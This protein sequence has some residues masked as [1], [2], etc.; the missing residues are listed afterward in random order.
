[1]AKTALNIGVR[2]PHLRPRR[3]PAW[4]P[5]TWRSKA[6][7][8]RH[9]WRSRDLRRRRAARRRPAHTPRHWRVQQHPLVRGRDALVTTT[10]SG[11]ARVPALMV[12]RLRPPAP[13]P[14][15][16]R[17]GLAIHSGSALN[18]AAQTAYEASEVRRRPTAGALPVPSR[19]AREKIWVF[20]IRGY[21]GTM[22]DGDRHKRSWNLISLIVV[23]SL[24]IVLLYFSL[25]STT[26][27]ACPL[28]YLILFVNQAIWS[29]GHCIRAIKPIVSA[30]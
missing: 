16:A 6:W 7:G 28:S 30:L 4:L 3:S 29:F 1:M 15:G 20:L 26:T 5:T 10:P 24:I 18:P 13:S 11:V 9:P 2:R 8:R 23:C 21:L 12:V 22:A 19:S 17:R 27:S 25:S 14:P